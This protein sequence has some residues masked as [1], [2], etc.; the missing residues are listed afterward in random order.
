M[1]TYGTMELIRDEKGEV[2]WRIQ[3]EP[4]AMIRLKNVIARVNK[5]LLGTVF[6]RNSPEVCRDLE[7]FV[8]RYPLRV[9]GKA[10]AVGDGANGDALGACAPVNGIEV[11]R[12]GAAQYR[13]QMEKL[14]SLQRPDYA[15]QKFDLALPAR[16]YQAVAAEAYLLRGS[17]LLADS[18]GLG[19]SITAL[20]ALTDKRT[21]PALIVCQAH[22]PKQWQNYCGKFLPMA[23]THIVKTGKLYSLP[24]ADIYICSYHKLAKW[25]DLLAGTGFRKPKAE[26][27]RLKTEAESKEEG[28][29]K[30]EKN[31]ELFHGLA[32]SR[33]TGRINGEP[34]VRSVVFDECQEL[35]HPDSQKYKAAKR[36]REACQFTHGLSATPIYNY[37]G[38]IFNVFDVLS[39][40]EIGGREEFHREW[41]IGNWKNKKACIREPEAFGSYLR[42]RGLM[43]RRTRGE[44]GM[45]L[46]P[47][48]TIVEEI[49]YTKE[50]LHD[51]DKVATELAHRIL[52]KETRFHDRGEAAREFD[53]KLRQA[54]GI[55]KAP[56]VA[57]FVKMLLEDGEKVVLTGWHRSVYDVWEEMLKDFRLVY[58]TGTESSGMKSRSVEAFMDTSARGADVFVMSLRSGSGLDGIQNVCS[59]IVHGELDWSPEVMKQCTGRLYRDGQAKSVFEYYMLSDGGSDPTI[60][61]ILGL[62]R[63]QAE[64]LL[65]KAE[66]GARMESKGI[67][68]LQSVDT[69]RVKRL[70]EDYLKRKKKKD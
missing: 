18:V 54:T 44:V 4:H 9:L 24:P 15:P 36:I 34:L 1:K 39:P 67:V 28:R 27:S 32:E 58:Y 50:V 42:E 64:R 55:A 7:W 69:A 43:M 16:H 35:R 3:A 5:V 53:M 47:V 65:K 17:Q 12:N 59:T 57:A 66:E 30:R 51:L 14:E 61:D 68:E 26:G 49:E 2:V 19:K 31:G 20:A 29:R 22:L 52:A 8:Q 46:P 56:F 41:C 38:E 40:G 60:A 13:E 23:S 37:G 70:A 10:E 62:K 21:L 63:D 45:E 6:V 11:L 33:P 48:Q 25:E